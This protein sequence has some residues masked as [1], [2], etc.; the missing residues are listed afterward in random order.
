VAG[1]N[2]NPSSFRAAASGPSA[3]AAAAVGTTVSYTDSQASLATL[4]VFRPTVGRKV[5]RR[6]V[7]ATRKNRRKPHCTRY[8]K[9]GSFTH[10]DVA[11]ANRLHFSGRI[12]NRKL[13]P[14]RYRLTVFASN[15]GGA[16]SRLLAKRF[17]I[18]R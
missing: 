2:I 15:S 10:A 14:G 17:V 6:C 12:R 1:L 4:T 7:K 13:K 3:T 5:N 8:V 18:V 9:V 11:G 16:R